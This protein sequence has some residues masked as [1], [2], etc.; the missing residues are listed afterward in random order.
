MK[1]DVTPIKYLTPT[2]LPLAGNRASYICPV[3]GSGSGKHG[4]G[5]T[6]RDNEYWKCWSCGLSASKIELFRIQNNLTYEEACRGILRY[7]GFSPVPLGTET[8]RNSVWLSSEELESLQL[9]PD[10]MQLNLIDG[11]QRIVNLYGLYDEDPKTYLQ[12]IIGRAKEMQKK[13]E[14]AMKDYADRN[15]PNARTVYDILGERFEESSYKK[16]RQELENRISVCKKII[17]IY[18]KRIEGAR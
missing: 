10:G 18:T 12:L 1:Y 4:S 2:F 6:S 11:E 9:C 7:Y 16:L 17:N 8:K 14:E 13:Y 3:C 15:A 5:M